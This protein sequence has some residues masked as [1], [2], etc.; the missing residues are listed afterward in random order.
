AWAK[1]AASARAFNTPTVGHCRRDCGL[2]RRHRSTCQLVRAKMECHETRA[3]AAAVARQRKTLGTLRWDSNRSILGERC[4][5]TATVR[6]VFCRRTSTIRRIKCWEIG[7][8]V[9]PCQL[10]DF[11]ILT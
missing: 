6:C 3:L 10:R 8:T 7:R 4:L 9:L 11:L 2:P 5:S 1:F